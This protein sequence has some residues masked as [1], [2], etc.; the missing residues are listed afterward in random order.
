MGK[1][2]Q[3]SGIGSEL[4]LML[5]AIVWGF[6]FVA[7]KAGM[8]DLGPL[9]FNGIRFL[10]GSVVLLPVIW[11]TKKSEFVSQYKKHNLWKAALIS[12]SVLFLAST[13]QQFGIVSTTAGNAGFITSIYVIIVPVIGLFFN[14]KV[15][16]QTWGGAI[17]SLVGLYFLSVKDGF[18]IAIGDLFVLGSAFIWAVQV[19]LAGYYAIRVNVIKLATIQFGFTGLLSLILSFFVESYS[20]ENINAA[21]IPLV[22]GG[23]MSVALAFTLQLIA[24]KNAKPSHAAIILSTESVFAGIGG[25]LILNE[26]LSTIEIVGATLMLSGVILSQIKKNT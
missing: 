9:A 4:L 15:N 26:R 1:K 5:A 2:F 14:Q 3:I 6:A 22:Y 20:M 24:Q 8:E 17:I 13:I 10:I 21:I 19:L 12:G 18:T 11:L 7:Q 16:F 25:W 23:L